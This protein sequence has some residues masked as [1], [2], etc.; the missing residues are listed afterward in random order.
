MNKIILKHALLNAIQ[1]EGQADVKAVVGKIFGENP[2][3]KKNMKKTMEEVNDMITEVN[4]WNLKKQKEKLKEMGIEVEKKSKEDKHKLPE[5]PNATLGKVVTA[6]PPEPSK[7]PHIGHAKA[8]YMNYLYAKKYNGKFLLRFED[9]N[10]KLVKKEYYDAIVDGLKWLGIEWDGKIEYITDHIEEYYEATEKLIKENKAYICFCKSEDIS[11]HRREMAE[12]SCRS[13]PIKENMDDWK[14]ML[15]GE[16][17]EGEA[18]VR[19]KI[20]MKHKNAVMRDPS[21]M[22]IIDHPHVRAGNKYKV[23]PMYDFGTSLMDSWMGVTHRIRSKEFEMRKELQTFIQKTLNLSITE[24]SEIARFNL[25]GVES[26]GRKIREMIDTGQ[27]LGWD[28]PR[29]TTLMSLKR[30]GFQPEAIKEFLVATGVSKTESTIE[31]N[32]FESFNKKVIEPIANRYFAVFDPI[33]INVTGCP[34]TTQAKETLHPDHPE[35]GAR[36]IPVNTNKI[37][38]TKEDFEKFQGKKVRLIGLFNVN[39]NEDAK[40]LGNEIIQEM[41]KIQWVSEE[42]IHV[43]ILMDD[44]SI[45]KGIVEPEVLRLNIGDIIQFMRFGFVRLDDKK[46]MKFYFTHK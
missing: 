26:S 20:S 8:A 1:Y 18:S 15:S 4:S 28:D 29:L 6:F 13:K 36:I 45:K 11:K 5:L 30:R 37:Y 41:P 27:L 42:N 12:C 40:Y 39:L 21:I 22:R 3:F 23:W 24:I 31:W 19:L 25:E 9:T 35:R 16:I 7:Y 32:K 2:D 17:K 44:G 46:R 38:V 43:E 10:P 34:K 33:C 14:K